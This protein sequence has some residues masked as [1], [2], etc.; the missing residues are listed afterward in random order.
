MHRKLI[1]VLLY[2]LWIGFLAIWKPG[3]VPAMPEEDLKQFRQK[4][5][6]KQ[7]ASALLPPLLLM[8]LVLGAIFA[9]VATPTKAAAVGALGA[10]VLTFL[11][12]KLTYKILKAVMS[13]TTHL[14]CMVFM[15]LIGAQ[16][17]TYVFQEIDGKKVI[18][19]IIME[20]Q[21][22]PTTFLMLVMLIIF[23]AGF[24]IDFIEITTI[25]VP[26]LTPPFGFSLFYLKGVAPPEIKTSH[27]YRGIIP[28]IFIQIIVII[29][30]VFWPKLATWHLD[31]D[32]NAKAP[33]ALT[34][35]GD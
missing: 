26:I 31:T 11:K 8:V 25:I 12:R 15:I 23:I 2:M 5:V 9:G 7:I 10:V 4:N 27:L 13:D 6:L 22:E 1:L 32:K 30:V 19:S 21:L 18:S 20:S 17:F 3:I 28:F 35:T 33:P 34:Q 16:F 29:L 24:F 14:S